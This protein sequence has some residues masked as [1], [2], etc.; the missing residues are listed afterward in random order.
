[1]VLVGRSVLQSFVRSDLLAR[2]GVVHII[3]QVIDP[4]MNLFEGAVFERR[5][6][7]VEG[8]HLTGLADVL[9]T[10]G[11]YTVFAPTDAAWTTL[12]PDLR[13]NIFK[14]EYRAQLEAVLGYHIALGAYPYGS[15]P[16]EVA[17]LEG[18]PLSIVVP[19]VG[20]VRI[21]P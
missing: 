1:E 10:G 17:T 4:P 11:P 5:K 13:V 14:P 21:G 12:P 18:S 2:N 3:P 6:R 8:L 16:N 15:L 9:A 7:F 19:P 20:P